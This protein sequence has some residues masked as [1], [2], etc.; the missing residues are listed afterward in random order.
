MRCRMCRVESAAAGGAGE[1]SERLAEY[2]IRLEA[3]SRCVWLK[4]G[5]SRASIYWHMRETQRGSVSSNSRCQTVQL[6]LYSQNLSKK[7]WSG[8]R[9]GDAGPHRP[10]EASIGDSA[11]ES[12]SV[13]MMSVLV[14]VWVYGMFIYTSYIYIYI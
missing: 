2:G 1:K 4:Q 3:S 5:L 6:Q 14:C 10:L 8:S 13:F 12:M 7:E 9:A 11:L